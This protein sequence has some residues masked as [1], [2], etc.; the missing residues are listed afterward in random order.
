MYYFFCILQFI[1][2]YLETLLKIVPAH[3]IT[4]NNTKYYVTVSVFASM[5]T[6]CSTNLE[7]RKIHSTP[8]HSSAVLY[9]QAYFGFLKN[10]LLATY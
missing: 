9:I 7:A 1:L 8:P 4:H 3:S 5:F 10:L 6:A 2:E